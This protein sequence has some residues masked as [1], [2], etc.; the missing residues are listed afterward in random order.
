MENYNDDI[1]ALW[2]EITLA[3]GLN[4]GINNIKRFLKTHGR[5]KYLKALYFAWIKLNLREARAFFEENK[6]LYHPI[7]RCLIQNKFNSS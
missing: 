5:L 1:K 3:K 7:A 4:D 6:Y 2:Y